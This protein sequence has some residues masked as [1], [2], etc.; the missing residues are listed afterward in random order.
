MYNRVEAYDPGTDA[1][2]ALSPLPTSVQGTGAA[3]WDGQLFLPGGGPSAG[4]D[5][6]STVLQVLAPP[7]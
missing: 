4:G 6:Q 7:G 3:V 1:W 2:T 5:E